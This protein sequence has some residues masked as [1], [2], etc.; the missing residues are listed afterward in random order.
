MPDAEPKELGRTGGRLQ[1]HLHGFT[2]AGGVLLAEHVAAE[3]INSVVV[4]FD[5]SVPCDQRRGLR[6]I[7]AHQER[8]T[9][10]LVQLEQ[11]D[12]HQTSSQ[13]TEESPF[14]LLYT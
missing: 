11:H 9:E 12:G 13:W 7:R 6:L 4:S 3:S 5:D 14:K 2:P 10:H 8:Q 1:R